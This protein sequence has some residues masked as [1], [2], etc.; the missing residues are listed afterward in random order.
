M[1]KLMI[2]FVMGLM[3]FT[4]VSATDDDYMGK[5]FMDIPI[6]ETCGDVGAAC[7]ATYTC[8]ITVTDPNQDVIV[9]NRLMT[10]NDTIYNFT[11]VDT[12][13]LGVYKIKTFCGNGTFSGESIDGKLTITTTGST[14]NT[15]VINLFLII[16][17]L[18]LLI[19]GIVIKS[20]PIGF[21]SGVL[22]L[23]AGVYM[24]IY[25]FGNFADMYTRAIGITIISLG[26][27]FIISAG[28]EWLKE[29]DY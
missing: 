14:D 9:L 26:G 28:W 7:D 27:L 16:G 24:T 13:V 21:L 20:Y 15:L 17:A 22:F 11:L 12:D 25:G 18:I 29:L 3:M 2:Y 4:L 6:I 10:R 1:N 5:Q 8:N 23:I 19:L